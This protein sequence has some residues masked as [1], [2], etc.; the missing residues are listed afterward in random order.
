MWAHMK[1]KSYL[2]VFK[3]LKRTSLR[4]TI[5]EGIQ[6][7]T[8]RIW[9]EE[10]SETLELRGPTVNK[11]KKQHSHQGKDDHTYTV[12]A[13]GHPEKNLSKSQL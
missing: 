12:G 11:R 13:S 2:E 4:D 9:V 3:L 1:E 5:W 10:T 7:P 8:E 6:T